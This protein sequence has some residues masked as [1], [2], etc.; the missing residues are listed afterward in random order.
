MD[1]D[2]VCGMNVSSDTDKKFEFEGTRYYFCSTSCVDKFKVNSNKYIHSAEVD[3]KS[4]LAIT[5]KSAKD[6]THIATKNNVIFT[7]P[8]HPEIQNNGPGSCLKCG[9]ALEPINAGAE[10][11]NAELKDM[12]LRFWVSLVFSLPLLLITMGDVIPGVDVGKWLG[13][14]AF[15]WLQAILATPVVLW[16]GWPFYIRAWQSFKTWD[17]NM[18]SLIGLGT[19]AAFVFS[20]FA[21]LLPSQLPDAFK[22]AAV[23]LFT[24]KRRRSSSLW[25]CWGKYLN[26]AL[27]LKPTVR[28]SLYCNWLLIP[29]LELNQTVLK[30]SLLLIKLKWATNSGLNPVQMC[31]LMARY[32]KA[33]QVSMNP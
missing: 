11:D 7:C 31:Q 29:P 17:L 19:A 8:M 5:A 4:S 26:F 33:T 27:D 25:Y 13:V 3:N 14:V 21:L 2:P 6:S 32:W 23:H 12:T 9:M 16:G 18:F 20:L 15:N 30:R 22:M 10:N 1:I 24:L 28:L